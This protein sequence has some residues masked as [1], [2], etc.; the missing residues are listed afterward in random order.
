M[1]RDSDDWP[2]L[3]LERSKLNVLAPAKL[4]E[5]QPIRAY[6]FKVSNIAQ[7]LFTPKPR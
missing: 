2:T 7:T 5:R 6:F 3:A 1:R 4:S